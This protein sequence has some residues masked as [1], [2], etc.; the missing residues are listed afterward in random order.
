MIDTIIQIGS[1]SGWVATAVFL[2]VYHRSARWWEHGYGRSLFA[3][4][5]IAFLFYTSSALFSVFGG[6]YW[7]RTTLRV[8]VTAGTPCVMWYLLITLIRG[9]LQARADRRE[10][11]ES[12]E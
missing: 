5:M 1:F 6:Q 10:R 8:V 2:V 11:A 9:T 12:S 4:V 3:L 7:G